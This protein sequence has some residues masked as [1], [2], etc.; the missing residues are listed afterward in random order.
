MLGDRGG[1]G[2]EATAADGHDE[3]LDLGV[4]GEPIHGVI[5]AHPLRQKA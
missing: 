5:T 4:I 3:G 1:P 2:R